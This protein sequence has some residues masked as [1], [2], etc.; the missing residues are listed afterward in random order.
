M[1][2]KIWRVF[3]IL[4]GVTTL[5]VLVYGGAS[6]GHYIRTSPRLEVK[7]VLVLGQKRV[8]ET[9][10]LAQAD[11]TD[12]VNVFSVDLEGIRE[13]V[14]T[15]QWV[16]HALVHRVLPDTIAI[17]IVEREPVGLAR[18]KGEIRQFDSDATLLDFNP[19]VGLNFPV[20][21]GLRTNDQ[22]A[23][24]KK[25]AL[26]RT[27]LEELHGQHEL[28]EVQIS[29]N[30]E[31]SVVA[32]SEPTIIHLGTDDFGGKWAH[33]L[34]LRTQIQELYP[35][36]AQVDFRFKNQVILKL[37]TDQP[38]EESVVWDVKKKSL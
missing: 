16:H 24:I 31:V 36:A 30:L 11:L 20:L 5:A 33:Y 12:R 25:V 38:A 28:S 18:V 27:I 29:D 9:E 1:K 17:R 3:Q 4:A 26:Y 13:R 32:E 6:L 7:K 19:E 14:E 10:V 35:S 34:Q 23:N 2:A 21:D 22:E 37:H 15:L 8:A